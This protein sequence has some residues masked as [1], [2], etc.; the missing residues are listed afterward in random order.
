[1][2]AAR[3]VLDRVCPARKGRPVTLAPPTIEGASDITAALSSV[4][5]AMSQGEIAPEEASIIVTV[6]EAKRRALE[7]VELEARVRA[8]EEV[9]T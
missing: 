3:L 4:T 2:V 5:D 6:I 7:T 1:M 8:L 9:G